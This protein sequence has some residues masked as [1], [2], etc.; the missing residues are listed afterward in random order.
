MIFLGP[1]LPAKKGLE[2]SIG[3]WAK[4]LRAANIALTGVKVAVPAI[5][6]VWATLKLRARIIKKSVKNHKRRCKNR[7]NKYQNNWQKQHKSSDSRKRI[8][9]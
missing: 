8:F 1:I 3:P 2:V 6:L 5:A 7:L 9:Y 4:A